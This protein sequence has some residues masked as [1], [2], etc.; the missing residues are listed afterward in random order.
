MIVPV[1]S[2]SQAEIDKLVMDNYKFAAKVASSYRGHG[3][4]YNDLLQ[5]SLKGFVIA[6]EKYEPSKKVKFISYA[7][8]WAKAMIIRSLCKTNNRVHIALSHKYKLSK[9]NQAIAEWKNDNGEE[10][11]PSTEWLAEKM[12]CSERSIN[13]TKKK[14]FNSVVSVH[15]TYTS[16][17]GEGTLENKVMNEVYNKTD[18]NRNPE[19]NLTF[20]DDIKYL[21][22]I[23]KNL[24]KEEQV[25]IKMKFFGNNTLEE[26]AKVINKKTPAGAK[27]VVERGLK[28]L[29]KMLVI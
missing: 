6:A 1:S 28:K 12:K 24:S 2:K 26:I 4:D 17:D 25:A 27:S 21:A 19:D 10:N 22:S 16:E 23:I 9:M 8:Y 13:N 18:D 3:M 14:G 20:K 5:E 11:E 15:D 29:N 7:V